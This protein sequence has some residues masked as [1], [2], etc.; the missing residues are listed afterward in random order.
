[1][2][3]LLIYLDNC[4][5]NRPFDDQAETRIRIETEAK[6]AV[7]ELVRS[8]KVDLVWSFILE[9]ENECNPFVKRRAFTSS[10][11]KLSK[12]TVP[13]DPEIFNRARALK[14]IGLSALD[15][16]HVA[17]AEHSHASCF[18]TTDRTILKKRGLIY[19]M[20]IQDPGEFIL[21]WE[22]SGK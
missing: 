6:L 21:E 2:A 22:E 9:Y 10:W 19:G 16:L 12:V 4:C 3:K 7:Q 15:A 17:C 13:P 8:G 20:M 14:D 5:Y 11:I 18:L 1:M